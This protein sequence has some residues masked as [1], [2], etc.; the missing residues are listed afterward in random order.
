MA[1]PSRKQ[2]LVSDYESISPRSPC[3]QLARGASQASRRTPKRRRKTASAARSD[4][5]RLSHL[6]TNASP[7]TPYR[8]LGLDASIARNTTRAQSSGVDFDFARLA[9]TLFEK[10]S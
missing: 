5:R 3:F 7:V 4:N 2:S 1:E 6:A 10:R 9:L 8:G